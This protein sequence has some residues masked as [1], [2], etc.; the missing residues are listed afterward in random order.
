MKFIQPQLP[1]RRRP[2]TENPNNNN[3]KRQRNDY[4]IRKTDGTRIRVCAATF[5]SVT[6]FSSFRIK[7][8]AAYFL[9]EGASRPERRGGSRA[10][11]KDNE[12]TGSIIDHIKSLKCRSSHYGRNK[13]IRSYLPPE[14]SVRKLYKMWCDIR[15]TMNAPVTSFGKYYKI[16]AKKFNLGFGNPRTDVCSFCELKK[17]EIS[18]TTD[19]EVR[20][21][22]STELKLHKIRAKKFYELLGKPEDGGVVKVCFDM[23]Q[24]QPLPK[25][26]ISDVYYMRQ[27]WLYNLTFVIIGEKQNEENTFAYTWT[28]NESGKGSN[29]VCSALSHFL[30]ALEAKYLEL[31]PAER[32]HTLKLFSDSCPGQ[33]KNCGVMFML[34]SHV[35][36]S[37]FQE[38]QHIF[39]IRGHSYMPADRVFGRS[40]KIIRRKEQI[41]SPQGY[42]DIFAKNSTVLQNGKDWII[43]DYKSLAGVMMKKKLPF[44]ITEQRSFAYRKGKKTVAVKHTYSGSECSHVV[45]KSN[46]IDLSAAL[47]KAEL[48]PPINKISVLKKANVTHLLKHVKL[49]DEETMF[50]ERALKNVGENVK[51]NVEEKDNENNEPFL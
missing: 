12:T 13:S 11:L 5:Q 15:N 4:F 49:T 2:R 7:S 38:I 22:V 16:F 30:N 31:S 47:E 32:P 45:L 9:K 46:R 35:Q 39:P 24:N 14:L 20:Q 40:E 41:V 3:K 34:L 10:S 29:E 27:L 8:I 17:N 25:L 42:Y 23:Q 1:K 51:D 50:Y 36:N 48:S 33:N 26:S 28:E 44:K 19:M 18:A 37:I 43:K 6:Q 21:N